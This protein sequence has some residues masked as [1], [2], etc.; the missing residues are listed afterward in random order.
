MGETVNWRL[1][2]SLVVV[3]V[4]SFLAFAATFFAKLARNPAIDKEHLN[5]V[6]RP[7]LCLE[8][9][10]Q[11]D[12][13]AAN[14]TS[15]VLFWLSSH[16]FTP[17]HVNFALFKCSLIA[18]LPVAMSV[19][20]LSVARP[21]RL[22]PVLV[23]CALVVLAPPL[24]YL[25]AFPS[26]NG[27][28]AV[29]GLLLLAWSLRLSHPPR[30]LSS[31]TA[32][33]IG[34]AVAMAFASHT[35]GTILCFLLPA[36][37]IAAIRTGD[38]HAIEMSRAGLVALRRGVRW[39][40]LVAGVVLVG[41]LWPFIVYQTR[42]L[43]LFFGGV[44]GGIGELLLRLFHGDPLGSLSLYG[45]DLAGTGGP[46]SYLLFDYISHPV[47]APERGGLVLLFAVLLGLSQ[48]R[49]HPRMAILVAIVL[50]NVGVMLLTA[51][52]TTGIRRALP[53]VCAMFLLAGVGFDLL[54]HYRSSS[55][56]LGAIFVGLVSWSAV[57]SLA[58]RFVGHRSPMQ[59]ADAVDMSGEHWRESER[60]G[61]GFSEFVSR[62]QSDPVLLARHARTGDLLPPKA[63]EGDH[64]WERRVGEVV[65]LPSERLL[66]SLPEKRLE[67]KVPVRL[68]ASELNVG[69]G[70]SGGITTAEVYLYV[71]RPIS[72]GTEVRIEL[73]GWALEPLAMNVD[74]NFFGYRPELWL[75]GTVVR[76]Y[77]RARIPLEWEPPLGY[78]AKYSLVFYSEEGLQLH[79]PL[80]T[81]PI[82]PAAWSADGWAIAAGIAAACSAF[83][84]FQMFGARLR[85]CVVTIGFLV[86][87]A[88][89]GDTYLL[90]RAQLRETY[91]PWLMLYWTDLPG[92]NFSQTAEQM[93]RQLQ[94]EPI[95]VP[96]RRM[97]P[98]YYTWFALRCEREQNECYPLVVEPFSYEWRL[99][100]CLDNL[101][102]QV[103]LPEPDV[104][105][106]LEA[107]EGGDHGK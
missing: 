89:I 43:R 80:G 60:T 1:I 57:A 84:L 74:S 24:N 52:P 96:P 48:I 26:E 93:Y 106:K 7:I 53:M 47:A 5:S 66:S 32:E 99:P 10:V 105:E 9:G 12:P 27:L 59:G 72:P 79:V 40:A 28:E 63:I 2:A 20:L 46:F 21:L 69:T 33:A 30:P 34:F 50:L 92:L 107:R 55:R 75:P 73:A 49:R 23:I 68:I 31:Q 65:F 13:W 51:E 38:W 100:Q 70:M 25:G 82:Y 36:L 87:A 17:S 91:Q 104:F 58:H 88:I 81:R 37:V 11:V 6:W 45:H 56:V 101:R 77:A 78:P 62:V 103:P 16:I 86:F 64:G 54:Y 29:F 95:V 61:L 14:F 18:L 83:L 85:R 41:S 98:M 39:P 44:R 3:Y 97:D 19:L 71:E 15:D 22:L 90:S 67:D 8:R 76:L 94:V 42:P 102:F 4:G 35:Y